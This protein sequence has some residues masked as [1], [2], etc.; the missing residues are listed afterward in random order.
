VASW[1]NLIA[2]GRRVLRTAAYVA[3]LPGI[4]ILITV[5]SISLIGQ[6]LNDAMNPRL[7]RKD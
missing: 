3:T 5:L 4:V 6:G 2:D 1:G 7:R